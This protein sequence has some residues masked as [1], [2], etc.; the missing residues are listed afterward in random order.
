M[1]KLAVETTIHLSTF[2]SSSSTARLAFASPASCHMLARAGQLAA[3][4][5]NLQVPL[6]VL[7]FPTRSPWIFWAIRMQ[8]NNAG[9]N[10][11]CLDCKDLFGTLENFGR[12][13]ICAV[14]A[15]RLGKL[16]MTS[17]LR[18]IIAQRSASREM[19]YA[20]AREREERQAQLNKWAN[21]RDKAGKA[22]FRMLRQQVARHSSGFETHFSLMKMLE[23]HA[24]WLT[25]KEAVDLVASMAPALQTTGLCI[26]FSRVVDAWS[27][28]AVCRT[29]RISESNYGP[30]FCYFYEFGDIPKGQL[31]SAFHQG[32]N[33]MSLA[34]LSR[35][36][37][38]V[39][40]WYS[41]KA[42]RTVMSACQQF[43]SSLMR[44][45]TE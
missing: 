42:W 37:P 6:R 28:M 15:A 11:R 33:E 7:T 5:R 32:I 8:E 30:F 43:D 14:D 10:P 20:S 21:H 45:R 19:T 27:L 13:T 18:E 26:L 2:M 35:P 31:P 39:D 4:Q 25:A 40:K 38:C 3:Q 23:E 36:V 9:M 22:S 16:P 34:D 41:S 12:C 1:D 24:L 29:S 17:S 44:G